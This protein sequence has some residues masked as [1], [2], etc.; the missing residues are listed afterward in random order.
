MSAQARLS[1]VLSHLQLRTKQELRPEF[2]L[3]PSE[4]RAEYNGEEFYK[5]IPNIAKATQVNITNPFQLTSSAGFD[6]LFNYISSKISEV[7]PQGNIAF[8]D[9]FDI[10]QGFECDKNGRILYLGKHSKLIEDE[11]YNVTYSSVDELDHDTITGT[12]EYVILNQV[13]F[14]LVND[15]ITFMRTTNPNCIIITID[16]I[17][18]LS[19]FKQSD[20]FVVDSNIKLSVVRNDT[21]DKI[22]NKSVVNLSQAYKSLNLPTYTELLLLKLELCTGEFT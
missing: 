1:M 7:C 20:V 11:E 18:N 4:E 3:L 19:S 10:L 2:P 17:N 14:S 13:E 15:L 8:C 12:Y 22:K 5:I 16:N 9:L 21:L 6:E